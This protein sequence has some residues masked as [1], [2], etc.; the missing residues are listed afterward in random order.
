MKKLTILLAGLLFSFGI[1]AQDTNQFGEK[2]TEKKGVSVTKFKKKL[3][4]GKEF[5]GVVTGKVK[6]VCKEMGCWLRLDDGTAEGIM[7]KMKD[8]EFFV[9]KDIDGRTVMIKGTAKETVTP[10]S[11]LKHYA[12]DAGKSKEEIAKITQDK[13]EIVMVAE[14]VKLFD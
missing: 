4:N 3:K 14:G 10:V 12:E 13:R 6:Q 1:M 9:P 8:H 5:D 7:V 11:E 2:F